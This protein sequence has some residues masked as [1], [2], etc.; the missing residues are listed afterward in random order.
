M[1]QTALE[2][3][4]HCKAEIR[5]MLTRRSRGSERGAYRVKPVPAISLVSGPRGSPSLTMSES[6][7]LTACLNFL[8]SSVS[9]PSNAMLANTGEMIP[10]WGVPALVDHHVR[11]SMNPAFSYFRSIA[12]SIGT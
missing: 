6:W 5:A 12:L 9:N 11:P 2:L 3:L 4:D 10:P 7:N 8:R 1:W